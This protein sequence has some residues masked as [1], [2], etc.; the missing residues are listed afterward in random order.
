MRIASL[1]VIGALATSSVARADHTPMA[2]VGDD[3]VVHGFV[4]QSEDQLDGRVT[5]SGG[6]A[7]PG[8]EVHVV[9]GATDRVVPTDRD[10]RYHVK[11]PPNTTALVFVYGDVRITS[12]A[13]SSHAG[14][15]G[16]TVDMH[17]LMIPT[18]PPKLR[19]RPQRTPYSDAA[20][21]HNQWLRAWLLLDID[22]SGAV[23]RMKLLD[24]AGYDLDPIAIRAGFALDFEP[25][26][27]RANRPI[28]TQLLWAVDWPPFWWN[29][30]Q[31][32]GMSA[33]IPAIAWRLP[34]HD[35][36]APHRY[37]R[38]CAPATIGNALS[39]PWIARPAGAP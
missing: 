8:A 22:P 27:D 24:H 1:A 23:T 9:S 18:T 7:L 19:R 38:S 2:I 10:G 13:A 35:G 39:A 4:W 31:G 36:T 32:D 26:R 25:A 30:D 29:V 17:E 14:D 20:S 15:D 16:E 11:L 12:T 6:H 3:N 5:D 21:D 33:P 28:R 34:C 37:E